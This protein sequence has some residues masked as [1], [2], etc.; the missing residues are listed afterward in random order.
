[1]TPIILSELQMHLSQALGKT[2][3]PLEFHPVGGGCI[4]ESGIL[5]SASSD[6][7]AFL[8]WN[9][10]EHLASFEAEA[11]GLSALAAPQ[12]IRVPRPLLP[13]GTL[14]DHAYLLMEVIALQ[15]PVKRAHSE[16][17]L[18]QQLA[19]LHRQTGETF[20]WPRHNVI[21]DTPQINIPE[22]D[23]LT[24]F[25]EHRLRFQIDRARGRGLLLSNA[26]TLLE[27]LEEFFASHTPAPS[28]LHGDL[29]SG[30]VGY[31]E[32]GAP[33]LVDPAVYHGDRETD[34]AFTTM[35]GGFSQTFYEAYQEAYPL[36]QGHA[37]RRDLY[38]LYHLL[39]HYNLFGGH[40]GSAAEQR[41][42]ALLT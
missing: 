21:G 25:R 16:R 12:V 2:I 18:G 42:A 28:L 20:G 23:W 30:N 33:V 11:D 10:A 14:G 8:K 19:A 17:Q 39:N 40:Y 37:R 6:F 3:G 27:R 38:N 31:D 13:P 35:F 36:D 22:D 26:D 29:W 1:M 7:R 15:P 34:L 24:F 9:S 32:T 5:S 41:I 4:H